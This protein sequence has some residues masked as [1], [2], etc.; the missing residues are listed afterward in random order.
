[1]NRAFRI[2][3]VEDSET[4][5]FKMRMLLEEQGWQVSIA[6]AAEE[7]LA[8]LGDPL[9]DLVVLD[10]NLPGMRGDEFCRRIR[11]NVNT[12]GI[13]I[14]MMTASA[15][16]TAEMQSLE[17]GANDYVAKSEAPEILLLRIRALF[18]QSPAQS[19]I[20]NPA[21]S[22]FRSSRILAIDDSPT[23]LAFLSEELRSHGYEVEGAT[24]GPQG[25]SR[26][27]EQTFDCA[28]VDL[29]M[30]E[31]DGIEVCRRIAA[32]RECQKGAVAVI[33]LTGSENKGEINRGFEAGAD[34]FVSKSSDVAVLRARIQAL[35]RRRFFQE[36]NGRIIEELRNKELETLRA[37]AER[38]MAEARAE[39]AEKLVQANE[40]LRE[41]HRKLKETQA[42]LIQ[43]EKMAS[44]GQLVAG[45]AHEI[46]NP[47]AFVVNNLFIVESGLD[48]LAPE[49]EPHL[50]EN[51]LKK[52]RKTRVRLGEMREG[53]D[54][55]KELVLDL[56]TFSRMDEGV[57]KAMDVVETIDAVLLLLKHKMNGRVLVEK[58][59][60]PERT[61]HANAG[62]IHQVLMNLIANAVDAIEAEGKI[63]ISTG[64]TPE[65]FRISV[66]DT[67]A[68]I[69]AAIRS[70]I[71]DPFF[72]TKPI[73]QGTG[74]G[75]SISYGIVQDH[76]GVIDMQS[77]EG[78]GTEFIVKI[79]LDLESRRKNE[80]KGGGPGRR[81]SDPG[82][83]RASV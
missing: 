45:I 9:P 38:Q 33:I 23:Y 7:A 66:R 36:E 52:L 53:V 76:G 6:G 11:M 72:T 63:F 55:V 49:I 43:N 56:R 41:A 34:D 64:Q 51:S 47:L 79:P 60:G 83:A 75:L 26:L 80:G 12:R 59:Y 18:R 27:A 2:V 68:G 4:Q 37:H 14:L 19:V 44:L 25:L 73:G 16:D 35:A 3:V 5:A 58:N 24:N 74:L 13:P 39:V 17:S 57:F 10:Y 22:A 20:L 81:G 70:K 62:Q 8:A 40:D 71:F 28:L 48:S 50:A 69:S 29:V 78:V 30:P 21:D 42:Q 46:N 15:P 31:M 54:R 65:H 67:G 82:V 61:L 1:M 77:E 32:T